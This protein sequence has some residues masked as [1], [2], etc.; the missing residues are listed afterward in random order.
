MPVWE[1]RETQNDKTLGHK[2]RVSE[3][4][5]DQTS[6][7]PLPELSLS[8]SPP[9]VMQLGLVSSMCRKLPPPTKQSISPF[10]VSN[11]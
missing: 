11:H 9:E 10:G 5:S 4:F 8:L 2:S 3:V 1:L 6:I 7:H